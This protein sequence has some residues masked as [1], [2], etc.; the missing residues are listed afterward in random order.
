MNGRGLPAAALADLFA[1]HTSGEPVTLLTISHASMPGSPLRLVNHPTNLVS[2][3]DTYVAFPF[4]AK[5]PTDKDEAPRAALVI[6]AVDRSIIIALRS[7]TSP[8]TVVMETIRVSAP[9][10][11]LEAYTMRTAEMT[12][13]ASRVEIALA[14]HPVF[15][16]SYPDLAFTPVDFPAMFKR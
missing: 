10:T 1:A 8:A 9:D 11:I 2:G 4:G 15:E 3:G 6:D 14:P 13:D 16:Q 7:I 12:Y 5:R